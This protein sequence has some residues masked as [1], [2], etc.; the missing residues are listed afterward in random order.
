MND[1]SASRPR[2]LA[3]RHARTIQEGR[4]MPPTKTAPDNDPVLAD[5]DLPLRATFHPAGFS[6]EVVT[7]SR[8]VLEAA[9]ESWGKFK[10]VFAYPPVRLRLGVLGDHSSK[11]PPPPVARS[12]G[13][14][15]SQIADAENFT[16]CDMRRG[17]AYGWVTPATV[18]NRSYL[19]YHILEGTVW[20]LLDQWFLTTLHGACLSRH[21]RGVL[22][23]GDSGAG[24][25]TLAYACARSGWKFLSDD[26]SSL[27]RN[28]P[29]RIVTGNPHQMR[30]RAPALDLFPELRNQRATPRLNGGMAVELDTASMPGIETISHCAIEH[31]VFLKRYPSHPPVFFPYSRQRAAA[32][33]ERTFCYGEAEIRN[34]QKASLRELLMAEVVEFRY[35]DLSLAVP[36]LDA[37]VRGAAG[38]LDVSSAG[39]EV[40]ASA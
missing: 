25:S 10:K 30:F 19:R 36:A 23:C 15:M 6:V 33:F 39:A 5:F 34:E 11:C 28:R 3:S 29:G 2:Q 1:E 18:R 9:Q 8:E 38:P 12:Q 14:L 7:N 37:L 17:F 26:A 22:L 16:I 21:G 20:I 27:I 35:D 13:H 4:E 40:R 32:W 31:I 24:K